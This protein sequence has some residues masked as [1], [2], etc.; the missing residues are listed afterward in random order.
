MADGHVIAQNQGPLIAHDVEHRTVLNV[1]SRDDANVVHVSANH[2][3][4]PNAAVLADAYRADDDGSGIDISRSR[5]LRV[6]AAI[7]PNVG[8]ASQSSPCHVFAGAAATR[9]RHYRIVGARYIVPYGKFWQTWNHVK[10][11]SVP[12]TDKK[13]ERVG[14]AHTV[15]D[16]DPVRQYRNLGRLGALAQDRNPSCDF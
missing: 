8:L 9:G 1:R 12:R 15:L 10:I 3:A 14:Q 5:D 6:F 2:S 4:G 13:G 7:R 11:T 16:R